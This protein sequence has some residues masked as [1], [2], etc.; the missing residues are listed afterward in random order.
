MNGQYCTYF[1]L[2]VSALA[3]AGSTNANAQVTPEALVSVNSTPSDSKSIAFD[4]PL[5]DLAKALVELGIQANVAVVVPFELVDGYKSSPL[6]GSYTLQ[7]A[8]EHIL[9][10][11]P[12][13]YNIEQPNHSGSK[14]SSI[15]VIIQP[16]PVQPLVDTQLKATDKDAS[17]LMEEIVVTGM[18][19]SLTKSVNIKRFSDGVLDAISAEDIGKFPDTN[20]AESLQRVSGVSISRANGEGSKVTV[21]G[22]GEDYNLVTLNGRAMPA[23]SAPAS[24]VANSR[25]FDFSNIASESISSVEVYKTS[26]ANMS[27][28]GIG[29]TINIKT[30]RPFDNPELQ[31]SI[32]IK[33]VT[34]TTNRTGRN[35]TPELTALFSWTDAEKYGV[36][37]TA[38]LQERDSGS[39]GAYVSQWNTTEWVELGQP[40]AVSVHAAPCD[41]IN[42]DPYS[43][44]CSTIV[45]APAVGQLYSMP[46]DL[47]YTIT[48]SVRSRINTQLTL[49]YRPIE[50]ITSTFDYTYSKNTLAGSRAEQSLRFTGNRSYLAFDKNAVKTPLVYGETF[51]DSQGN[52]TAKD[53]SFAQQ[54]LDQVNKNDSLGLNILF[55]VNDRFDITL[56]IHNSSSESG[57]GD[58]E[59]GSWANVSIGANVAG[60]LQVDWRDDLPIMDI[61]IDDSLLAPDGTNDGI[62]DAGD[63]GTQAAFPYYSRQVTDI[64]QFQL[65]GVLELDVALI[66]FGLD[67]RQME[68]NTLFSETYYIMGD[69]GISDP[70]DVP[71]Y[72]FSPR[73]FATE[74][75]DYNTDG[76]F[77]G[78]FDADALAITGWGEESEYYKSIF[79]GPFRYTNSWSVDR[80]IGED[81]SA[82]YIQANMDFDLGSIPVR[83]A[84][85]MR[86]EE[87][88]VVSFSSLLVPAE[89]EWL[90]NNDFNTAYSN[91]RVYTARKASY[92]NY[93]PNFDIALDVTD[94]IVTRFSYNRTIARAPY[95]QLSSA[96]SDIQV[97]GV[98]VPGQVKSLATEG[99]P[100][101]RPL[102][103]N[104]IDLSIEFYKNDL[105]Y[106]SAGFYLKTIENFI[107]I[108]PI[109]KT[110]YGLRDASS[111]PR[112]QAAIELIS[113]DPNFDGNITETD[114]F[115][116]IAATENNDPN[117]GGEDDTYY[118]NTYDIEPKEED[119][120]Y[121]VTTYT[122]INNQ[123]AT[124]SGF[125]F[126]GQHFF[127]ES[128]FGILANYTTVN[129]DV[130]F[131]VTASANAAQF[132]LIGL[133]DTMN[134]VAMY[135]KY[136]FQARLAYNWRDEYLAYLADE[137]KFTK[138]YSQIDFLISYDFGEQFTVSFEGL[139]ITE[140][141]SRQH[142]RSAAQLW[143][144]E[145]L[146]ARY[147]LGVRYGFF[148]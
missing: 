2:V 142:G 62:F 117:L 91:N 53:I 66:Q 57:P 54:E 49:Q 84:A 104:N 39:V 14:Q 122:P 51:F 109:V 58:A 8:L 136:G 11:T 85:G 35:V 75:K 36:S 111:G 28:G 17:S 82:L 146:G 87:T 132:A 94:N 126:A 140:E 69:W 21:R 96:V 101:L 123:E 41:E 48:D 71:D 16:R 72:L 70:S 120:L 5:N 121:Q 52:A 34:D 108:E 118:G 138:A 128:G 92:Y 45:N 43:D 26:S 74:F 76:M 145:Q 15:T 81:T 50:S 7:S 112:A 6:V 61:T 65:D 119:P 32:S 3:F 9:W 103:S 88:E 137:P 93:L 73:N 1:C 46:S 143:S 105:S 99:T 42:G 95:N 90:D 124:I 25:A 20:L 47:H 63:M 135:E 97:L 33:A 38:S 100:E 114:L 98:T 60:T 27:T 141:N 13:T 67:M 59:Y 147:Q 79:D 40:G 19:A 115:N 86:Y 4:L 64:S 125:E 89:I 10:R 144:L 30:A 56:D 24:E 18:R 12:L 55:E 77:T 148:L 133:S 116:Q 68:S 22:F 130:E 127:G 107:G 83:V 134:L 78:G 113:S 129:G 139:N 23:A 29:A 102:E 37:L 131:D 31:Q 44:Q 80:T 106:I 110:H